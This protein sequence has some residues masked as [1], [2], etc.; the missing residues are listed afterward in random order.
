MR[1]TT[2]AIAWLLACTM[3][4]ACASGD[5][6]AA[7]RPGVLLD[8]VQAQWGAPKAVYQHAQGQRVFYS[9]LPWQVRRLDFDAQG[10]LQQI[11]EQV[12]SSAKFA[13]IETG[14][15][16]TTDV[17]QTFGPPARRAADADK[18]S[19]WSYFFLEYSVHRQA[20]IHFDADGTVARV[21]LAQDPAADDRY[22]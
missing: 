14:K 22:R 8:D 2:H 15:W 7:V 16:R 5:R 19:V 10:R 12:L 4:A 6:G 1:T 11:H 21:D 13:A 3:L 18:G 9:P 17:Q 20:R